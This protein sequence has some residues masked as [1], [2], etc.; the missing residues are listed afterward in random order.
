MAMAAGYRKAGLRRSE[1][2]VEGV[3]MISLFLDCMGVGVS[4]L[5]MRETTP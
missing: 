2:K 5:L 1:Y 4:R 3:V